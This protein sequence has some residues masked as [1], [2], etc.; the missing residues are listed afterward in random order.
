MRKKSDLLATSL[1]MEEEDE[2]EIRFVNH[3]F[4]KEEKDEDE[5]RF[6]NHFSLWRRK[7]RKRSEIC[8]LTTS[9]YGGG[10]LGKDHVC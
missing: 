6:A 4:T 1:F 9:L 5:I 2:E 7:M 8:L 10:R 3:F